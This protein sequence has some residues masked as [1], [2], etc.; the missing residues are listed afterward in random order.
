[1]VGATVDRCAEENVQG[2]AA[3]IL[4]EEKPNVQ[5]VEVWHLSQC[6]ARVTRSEA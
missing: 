2:M 3:D 5:S 1:M 4:R 6:V